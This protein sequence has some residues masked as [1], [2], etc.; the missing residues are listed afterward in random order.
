VLVQL[1]PLAEGIMAGR[2]AEA[3]QA[4]A[5]LSEAVQRMAAAWVGRAVRVAQRG[6][7]AARGGRE[8]RVRQGSA[9]SITTGKD[10]R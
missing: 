3:G 9:R 8:R 4:P 1:S 7:A 6:M 5:T 2:E 10:K